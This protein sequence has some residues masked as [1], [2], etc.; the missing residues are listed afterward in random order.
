[1]KTGSTSA[2]RMS[3][4]GPPLRRI[5]AANRELA[6]HLKDEKF[7]AVSNTC[8]YAGGP[9]GEGRLDGE[10]IVCPWNNSLLVGYDLIKVR[11]GGAMRP[12]PMPIRCRQYAQAPLGAAVPHGRRMPARCPRVVAG[13]ERRG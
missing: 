6:I 13:Y 11:L 10:Y 4:S 12:L 3:F 9:L 7:G 8:N 1:M 5:K 2:P